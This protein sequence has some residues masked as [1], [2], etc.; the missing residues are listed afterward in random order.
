M[1]FDLGSYDVT[2]NQSNAGSNANKF[3][4]IQL[5]QDKLGQYWTWTRWGRVGEGGQT[6][7]LGNGSFAKASSEFESKFKS[8]TGNTWANR[9]GPIRSGKYAFIERSYDDSDDEE[10]E[11]LPGAEKRKATN[12]ISGIKEEEDEEEAKLVES[13]LA[14]PVQSLIKLIFNKEYFDNTLASFDYDAEKLP[15]GKLS[16]S[17]LLKGYEI[18][19]DLAALVGGGSAGSQEV[20][21]LSNTYLSVIPHVVRR[22]SRPPVLSSMDLIK[23]EVELIEALTD[24]QLANDVM[25]H[26]KKKQSKEEVNLLD[27]QF[28][29]LNLNEMTPLDSHGTEF[30]ELASYLKKSA[31]QTHGVRYQVR[32]IFRIER[33]GE[34]ERF[35]KSKYAKIDNSDKRLLWHGSRCTNFGGILSQGLRIAPPEAPVSGYM[36]GKGIYLA[37]ISTKSAGY[38]AAHSSGGTGLLLLCEAELGNPALKLTGAAYDAGE[39]AANQGKISTHGLGSTVPQAWKDAG[40]VHDELKGVQMPDVISKPPGQSTEVLNFGLLYNEYIVYDVAQVRLRYLFRVQM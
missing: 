16:K 28:Q 38:C 23:K 9:D 15:L 14:E 6:A 18:L 10:L 37:D 5:L 17:T 34:N 30:E 20:A 26:A 32:D 4:R 39:Q 2:L 27:Q 13:K 24:M 31:G 35:T 25:K 40:C 12:G 19:K 29:G 21:D 8:K 1:I 33:Q 7:M 22:S 11:Q 36:F 3:Y